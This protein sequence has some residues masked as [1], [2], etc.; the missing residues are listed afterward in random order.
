KEFIEPM[1]ITQK[2]MADHLDIPVQR[3]NEIIRGKRGISPN[4]AWLLSQAF[5][6]S[7]EFWLNL[8]SMY[9]LAAHPPTK[10]I[11]PFNPFD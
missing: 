5:S 7:P 3:V 2:Q 6:T 11:K 9:D 10:H 8:H 4:T 1:G